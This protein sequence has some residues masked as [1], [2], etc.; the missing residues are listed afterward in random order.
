MQ[1][2]HGAGFVAL[3]TALV[4]ACHF[5]EETALPDV[6]LR[7]SNKNLKYEVQL[8]KHVR[9]RGDQHVDILGL[10]V[11]EYD[12]PIWIYTNSIQGRVEAND[13]LFA[14]KRDPKQSWE[15]QSYLK[16]YIEFRGTVLSMKLQMPVYRKDHMDRNVPHHWEDYNLNGEYRIIR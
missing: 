7:D 9:R 2:L 4:A 6:V 16:G 13:L 8:T 12:E 1:T 3:L 15:R 11:K 10:F 14:Y 5:Y